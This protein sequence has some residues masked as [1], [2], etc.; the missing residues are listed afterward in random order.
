LSSMG[1]VASFFK[2]KEQAVAPVKK[3]E[4][5]GEEGEE[6]KR[7]DGRRKNSLVSD[8][9]LYIE[10]ERLDDR[11][12]MA[13]IMQ[14]EIDKKKKKIPD[15]NKAE[16]R[17][18]KK[19]KTADEVACGNMKKLRDLVIQEFKNINNSYPDKWDEETALHIA[20]REGYFDMVEFM[21][22]PK[23]RSLFDVTDLEI[24]ILNG[25][26]R[27]PLHLLFTAPHCTFVSLKYG[28]DFNS[29]TAMALRPEGIDNDIDFKR[30]G[31]KEERLKIMKLLVE[32]GADVNLKDF[33]DYTPLQYAC[34]WSWLPA[35]EVLLEAG[36]DIEAQNIAGQSA[37]HIAVE[38]GAADVVEYLLEETE[39]PMEG[40]DT[41]GE[42]PLFM[43]CKK[44][45]LDIVRLLVEFGADTN[46]VSFKKTTPLK[47]SC[48]ENNL[49]IINILLDYKAQ[50]RKSAFELC[51]WEVREAINK[52]VEFE[53]A[54][55]KR[56]AE[57]E[58]LRNRKGLT[59]KRTTTKS[60]Y[61]QWVPYN[62]KKTQKRFY[63]NKVSREILW[64][65]PDD[66]VRDPLYVITDA[67]YGMHFYH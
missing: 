21:I 11:K 25:K 7:K 8:M 63:Y 50:R 28:F 29:L 20:C 51:K 60:A 41:D 36:A 23:N 3:Q 4:E 33:H 40:R 49:P 16:L 52:R 48:R 2:K 53:K 64:D 12:E 18:Q 43:A 55:A 34:I 15:W 32:N 31:G 47:T 42:T 61:Q 13:K 26:W 17:I 67:T 65:M 39:I 35:V 14:P 10:N 38:F 44:N 58:A 45:N 27:S 6:G 30:P 62:D 9:F 37:L 46:F 22:N 1:P 59:A 19:M 57:E 66:Y 5:E 54:E 24:D 56:L